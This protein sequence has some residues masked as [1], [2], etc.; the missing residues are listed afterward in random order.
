MD[1]EPRYA[2]A[3]VI[4]SSTEANMYGKSRPIFDAP[5]FVQAPTFAGA[6]YEPFPTGPGRP[7]YRV[8]VDDLIRD[9][10]PN[11]DAKMV[12][13]ICGDTGGIK[14][15][16]PQ[17]RVVNAMESDCD[18]SPAGAKPAFFYHLGDVVYFNGEED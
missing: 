3:H 7:P 1:A 17:L 18:H 13:H 15:P 9:L 4:P 2:P 14:D 10:P 6:A 16:N 12:F 8:N 11:L 5:R